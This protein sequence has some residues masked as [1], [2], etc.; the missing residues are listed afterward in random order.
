MCYINPSYKLGFLIASDIIDLII[1]KC[2]LY[3]NC[4]NENKKSN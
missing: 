2:E 1:Q 3:E 4:F